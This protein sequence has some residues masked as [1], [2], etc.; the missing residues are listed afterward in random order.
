MHLT[1]ENLYDARTRI[2]PYIRNT[3]LSPIILPNGDAMMI[4]MEN[5]QSTGSFKIRGAT[6]KILQLTEEERNHGVI[7]A[8][9]GNH[10]QGVAKIAQEVGIPCTIVMPRTAPLSKV[11][12]TESYG[13]NVILA[14]DNYDS[15][16]AYACEVQE[17]TGATFIHPFNDNNVIAGQASIGL[18]ILDQYPEVEQ[19][20]VPVGGGGLAAGVAMAVKLICPDVKVIGVEPIQAA[21]MHRSLLAGKIITLSSTNTIADGIAVKTPGDL[22]YQYCQQFLDSVV[23]VSEDEIASTMLFLIEKA[24]SV[25][26]GAGAAA[27]AAAYAGKVDTSLNTVGILSGGNLDVNMI[28]RVIERGLLN[29]GRKLRIILTLK[30]QPG[31]LARLSALIADAGANIVAIHYDRTNILADIKDVVADIEL[32]TRNQQDAQ[33]ISTILREE[34][35]HFLSQRH[36]V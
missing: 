18:E 2:N 3:D 30:D 7:A 32:E 6:N 33:N 29:S 26:E 5:L 10:A 28:A 21:S 4:K 9:A 25:A 14:G 11:A 16:Y 35:Y 36:E 1:L 20:L 34:G 12:A 8:S 22:T 13:A 24:K 31:E 17:Q 27:I 15:S 19:I 23:E